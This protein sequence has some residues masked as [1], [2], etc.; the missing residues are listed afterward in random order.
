MESIAAGLGSGF[1]IALVYAAAAGMY[2]ASVAFTFFL[3]FK[4]GDP[5]TLSNLTKLDSAAGSLA[6][7]SKTIAAATATVGLGW[8]GGTAASIKSLGAAKAGATA[9]GRKFGAK[10]AFGHV[11][12]GGL[13][14]GAQVISRSSSNVP[15]LGNMVAEVKNS[16]TEGYAQSLAA[17]KAGG[18][19]AYRKARKEA[20]TMGFMEKEASQF[21]QSEQFGQINEDPNAFYETA[22]HEG[23]KS[24]SVKRSEGEFVTSLSPEERQRMV[25]AAGETKAASIKAESIE[26]KNI[27]L[28]DR[29]NV[30][31][32]EATIKA[33]EFKSRG[34]GAADLASKPWLD[35][36]GNVRLDKD[37]RELT[38]LDAIKA[39]RGQAAYDSVREYAEEAGYQQ[40]VPDPATG[41][42]I[43]QKNRERALKERTAASIKNIM[44]DS[45]LGGHV[46]D[47]TGYDVRGNSFVLDGPMEDMRTNVREFYLKQGKSIDEAH[48]ET[49]KFMARFSE[50]ALNLKKQGKT[51]IIKETINRGAGENGGTIYQYGYA[52]NP[53]MAAGKEYYKMLKE[54]GE[55]LEIGGKAKVFKSVGTV[56]QRSPDIKGQ[57]KAT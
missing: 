28:A 2:A 5:S 33:S 15:F 42:N 54:Q 21:G 19:N 7:L 18:M 44:K 47:F 32:L 51:P 38:M 39:D 57:R 16:T 50:Q 23:Q 8:A 34:Q 24:G 49:A 3:L 56:E 22:S 27:D 17:T 35:D 13:M 11:A 14:Q 40:Y 41:V 46:P 25:Q 26:A 45:R 37:G 29:L 6:E 31:N 1:Q 9:V 12:R 4:V 52:V 20:L 36:E 43:R 10:E 55:K 53:E 30:A 48:R